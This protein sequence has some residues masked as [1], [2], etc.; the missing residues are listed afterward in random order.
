MKYAIKRESDTRVR[1][2]VETPGSKIKNANKFEYMPIDISIDNMNAVCLVVTPTDDGVD[3]IN[4]LKLPSFNVTDEEVL[5]NFIL[6]HLT[7]RGF[8]LEKIDVLVYEK[9]LGTNVMSA[10]A[11]QY[12]CYDEYAGISIGAP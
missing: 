1:I 11:V 6:T 5:A 12:G 8:D 10:T 9:N 2:R 7:K 3:R 4:F